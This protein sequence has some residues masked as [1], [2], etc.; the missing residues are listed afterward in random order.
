MFK[1][2]TAM[3]EGLLFV[4]VINQLVQNDDIQNGGLKAAAKSILAVL[5]VIQVCLYISPLFRFSTFDVLRHSR[6]MTNSS[7]DSQEMH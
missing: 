5:P 4:E 1:L 7:S 3:D 2:A 6:V